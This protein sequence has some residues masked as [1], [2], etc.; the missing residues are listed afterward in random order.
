MLT[1]FSLEQQNTI[2]GTSV[3]TGVGAVL[4]GTGIGLAVTSKQNTNEIS[5]A[6]I[7]TLTVGS[8]LTV[9]G[10]ITLTVASL[11]PLILI[12]TS[13]NSDGF[14]AQ[15]NSSGYVQW[16]AQIEGTYF[17][18]PLRISADKSG[19]VYVT[20]AF[21]DL[22]LNLYDSKKYLL[23]TNGITPKKTLINT[24]EG[25]F[26]G[27][28]AQY[29]SFGRIQW[30]AQ[31]GGIKSDQARGISADNGNV[32]VTG[33]FSSDGSFNLYDASG[34]GFKTLTSEGL[35]DA[36]IAQYDSSGYVKWAAQMGGTLS[37][38]GRGISADNGNVY[39]TGIFSSDGSFNLY[40]ASGGGFKT[41]TS[42]GYDDGFIAQYDSSGRIQWAAKMGGI[43]NDAGI[44]ISADNGNVYVT[45]AFSDTSFNLYDASG[46]GF[47][48]LKSEGGIDGFIAQ[49]D[50]SGRIQWAAQMGGTLSDYGYGISAINGNVYVTGYFGGDT[51]FNLYDA[52][53]GGFKTLTNEGNFDAFIAQYDSSGYVQWAAKMGGIGNDGGFGISTDQAGNLY[54][55]G[56]FNSPS[57]NLYDANGGGFKTLK[58]EGGPDGF[59]AQYDSSGNVK[60]AAKMGGI[61]DD[62][63]VGIS[64]IN[65]NVYVTGYFDSTIF[66]FYTPTIR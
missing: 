59:I 16:A 27:F 51:S 30:A 43:G 44:G 13:S 60:W 18:T 52:S 22:I 2:I 50:S 54:V 21:S 29:D 57:F 33:I 15:Y 28:I 19:N 3:A 46:G 12:N 56:S 39:V 26:D 41:L 20:G 5:P 66:N 63:S 37:D 31:M 35:R 25:N 64:A 65:G 47:K 4:L 45:G 23:D 7:A 17:G 14:I 10:G 1:N 34:G 36:F 9:G 40:D 55:T 11:I 42:E 8:I 62:Q 58:S 24:S 48:T 49:Y 38:E 6:A 61:G 53:G 32:Y